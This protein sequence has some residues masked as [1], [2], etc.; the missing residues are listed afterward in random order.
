MAAPSEPGR[1]CY[2]V[3]SDDDVWRWDPDLD[4]WACRTSHTHMPWTLLVSTFGPVQVFTP[5]TGDGAAGAAQTMGGSLPHTVPSPPPGPEEIGGQPGPMPR[6][7][8]L[9]RHTDVSQVS[10][11]GVVAWG[12]QFPDG[13]AAIRWHGDTPST[14]AWNS[15][16]D[17][18]KVHGHSGATELRWLDDQPIDLW[19][20]EE[21]PTMTEL[22]GEM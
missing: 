5:Q 16:D 8:Q 6:R 4:Q 7:F 18:L 1:D 22:M 3:D 11:V 9:Y 14:V 19:P 13:A 15:V 21:R 20:A 2:V 17:A 12:V 10:G